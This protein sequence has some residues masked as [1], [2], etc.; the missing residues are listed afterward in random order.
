V[1]RLA[2][3]NFGAMV[4]LLSGFALIANVLGSLS[5]SGLVLIFAGLMMLGLV[6]LLEKQRRTLAKSIKGDK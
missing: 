6:W 5:G 1:K 3:V 2:W 4:V